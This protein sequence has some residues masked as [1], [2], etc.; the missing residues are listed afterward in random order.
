M[1]LKVFSRVPSAPQEAEHAEMLV[2]FKL[3]MKGEYED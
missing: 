1:Q 2:V 3:N